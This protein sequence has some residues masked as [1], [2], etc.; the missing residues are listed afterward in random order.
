MV[1]YCRECRKF[2]KTA[3]GETKHRLREHMLVPTFQYKCN[4]VNCKESFPTESA[5]IRHQQREHI[6]RKMVD[7]VRNINL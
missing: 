7:V 1:Y 6:S 3:M 4:F 2:F 5:L